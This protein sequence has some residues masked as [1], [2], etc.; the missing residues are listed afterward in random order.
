M[1]NLTGG[2]LG[3][4]QI[5]RELGRGGMA[6]VYEAQQPSLGRSVAIK[7]LPAEFT[8][9][10]TFV[11]RFQHEARAAARLNHPN[12]VAIYDVGEQ[13]GVYYIVMQKLEGE[14]L[15]SLIQRA[16][17]LPLPR[18][19]HIIGQVAAALDYAHAQ[20]LVHRDIKPANII[21]G[22]GDHATVMDFGIA[23]ALAGA[24]LTQSGVMMGTPAYMSPEQA[25]GK[26]VEPASDV[27]SLGLVLY[28][29]LA[30]RV[31]FQADSTPA[32]LY[33]QVHES[34]PPLR[35]FAPETPPS[36][37]AVVARALAKDS[38]QRFRSAGEMARALQEAMTGRAVTPSP[39]PQPKSNRA[40]LWGGL[41]AGL[42]VALVLI[43]L[44]ARGGTPTPSTPTPVTSK[45]AGQSQPSEPAAPV[46]STLQSTTPPT[47][48][49]P[50]TAASASSLPDTPT[51][52]PLPTEAPTSIPT[53]EPLGRVL[54]NDLN[55]RAGPDRA[56]AS[57]AKLSQGE[58]VRLL[59][60]NDVGDWLWVER[61]N[62]QSG[63][64][65]SQ[66]IEP[67]LPLAQ[68]AV[69]A[70][71]AP[72]ACAFG[73]DRSLAGA[74]DHG[75]LGCAQG[76][77]LITWAAWEPF[78][79]GSMIWLKHNDQLYLIYGSGGW[80]ITPDK[81]DEV[82]AAPSRGQPPAGLRA[83][84][85]GFGWVWSTND[86]IFQQLGWARDIEKGICVLTQQFERGL[87]LRT[88]R[89][90]CGDYNFAN[91]PGFGQF[92]YRLNGDGT[93]QRY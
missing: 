52:T 9:D 49:A 83:P 19:A 2:N 45:L 62:G 26:P 28:Q 66:F 78:E 84:V 33:K 5:L 55:L 11:Q 39:R 48:A 80:Q 30:G 61:G 71:P 41:A 15:H 12:I 74:Y 82:S 69:V 65:A 21:V 38:A 7:V 27:Y 79:R 72:P 75:R 20:N 56:F 70:T 86:A 73:V 4:Y 16:G 31:P 23:K 51:S 36:V 88:V 34:P 35:S 6:I 25:S 42:I 87:L 13:N 43:L 29:M 64:V 37:E 1:T 14:S 90:N 44:L 47:T 67:A 18:V 68:V 57:L 24:Q 22:Q 60:R 58:Q 10:K 46:Q 81:W 63:W 59:G 17:R 3:Q 8:F 53:P 89:A 77:S 50:A 92:F 40:L 85:R 91:E 32:L 93:W 54:E 76:V